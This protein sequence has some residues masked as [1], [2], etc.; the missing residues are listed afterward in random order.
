MEVTLLCNR[1][2]FLGRGVDS[3]TVSRGLL[4]ASVKPP[5]LSTR[6]V[7]RNEAFREEGGAQDTGPKGA[8][9]I[10][11]PPPHLLWVGSDM[12]SLVLFHKLSKSTWPV[13]PC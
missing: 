10:P 12:P 13:Y 7:Y 4:M 6:E 11:V 9:V 1:K 2:H 3:Y 8:K 5:K